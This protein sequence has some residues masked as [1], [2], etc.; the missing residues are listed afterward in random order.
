MEFS[1]EQVRNAFP[2]VAVRFTAGWCGPCKALAPIWDEVA[3]KFDAVKS[4]VVDVDKSPSLAESFGVRGIPTMVFM[5]DGQVV[6]TMVGRR[7]TGE[8]E[9]AFTKLSQL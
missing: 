6:D 4:V 1:E 3:P 2:K 7:E 9:A 8:I 5:K